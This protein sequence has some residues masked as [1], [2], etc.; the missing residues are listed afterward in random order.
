MLLHLFTHSYLFLIT[1]TTHGSACIF[2]ISISN[3]I[4]S[5]ELPHNI[6]KSS[7]E[8]DLDFYGLGHK[9]GEIM[10]KCFADEIV[11]SRQ[12]R[13]DAKKHLDDAQIKYEMHVFAVEV[14]RQYTLKK[15][16]TRRL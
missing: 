10:E 2:S 5:I 7:F 15:K 3:L 8:R 1:H 14:Y 13:D 11:S 12:D 16:K 9:E 4:L 6:P